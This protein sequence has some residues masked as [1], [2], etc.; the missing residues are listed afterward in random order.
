MS[1]F[2]TSPDRLRSMD[3]ERRLPLAELARILGDG[4]RLNVLTEGTL[5]LLLS[6][7]GCVDKDW[8]GQHLDARSPADLR[9]FSP[10]QWLLVSDHLLD[11]AAI[12]EALRE[13]MDVVDQSHG[14][15]RLELEGRNVQTVLAQATGLDLHG[16]PVALERS[17]TTMIGHIGVHLTQTGAD[18]FELIVMRS[19]VESLVEEI[20]LMC[21]HPAGPA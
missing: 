7:P 5:L 17:A 16:A 19:L 8:I 12:A 15:V 6:R 2:P 3:I 13:G 21:R 1:E 9:A 11:H 14:R 20:A 10:G 4:T 18:V